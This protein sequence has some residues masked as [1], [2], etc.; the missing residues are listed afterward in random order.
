MENFKR[1]FYGSVIIGIFLWFFFYILSPIEAKYPPSINLIT[2]ITISYL[3]LLVGFVLPVKNINLKTKYITKNHTLI[4]KVLII[5]VFCSFTVRY[6]DLFYI[7]GIS[8][9]NSN[10]VNKELASNDNNFSLIFGLFSIFRVLYFLPLLYYFKCKKENKKLLVFCILIFFLPLL[11]GYLRDSRRII[12]EVFI[13]LFLILVINKKIRFNSYKTYILFLVTIGILLI[14]SFSVVENRAKVNPDKFFKKIL[15]S[16]YNDFVPLKTNAIK[17]IEKNK[18]PLITKVY[19]S[20]IHIGQYITHGV[21]E[22]DYMISTLKHHKFGMY[23]FYLFIKFL[24]K[25]KI[26]NVDLANLNNPTKRNTYITFFGGLFYDFGW[27]GPLL[28][29]FYGFMQK[30]IFFLE[31]TNFLISPLVLILI[32]TNIFLLVMNFTRAQFLLTYGVYFVF[33]IIYFVFL[34]VKKGQVI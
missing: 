28:M 4:I 5:L 19:F 18:N 24:N 12:F 2:Y 27:F 17:F 10:L 33:L 6:I 21:F 22:M 25:I 31:K 30:Q 20:E 7:R 1:K 14:H 16:P 8:F 3:G 9:Y 26:T 29:I 34:K 11:E 23:N 15:K 32:F 13:F